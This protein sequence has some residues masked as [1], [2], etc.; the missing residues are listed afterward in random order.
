MLYKNGNY[1]VIISSDGSKERFTKEDKFIPEYPECLDIK[2]TDHCKMGCSF[3]YESSTKANRHPDTLLLPFIDTL[4]PYTEVAININD[5][6]QPTLV[7]FLKVLKKK[8]VYTNITINFHY[9]KQYLYYIKGLQDNKLIHGIGISFSPLSS[10]DNKEL[11]HIMRNILKN[12]VVHLIVGIADVEL[13][14]E[15]SEN[16]AKILFLGYK[17]TGFGK[18][19]LEKRKEKIGKKTEE[20]YEFLNRAKGIDYPGTIYSFDNLAIEQ[21]H[22]H[23][24]YRD[25]MKERYMGDEGEFTFYIDIPNR[26]YYKNSIDKSKGYDFKEDITEMFKD[27]RKDYEASI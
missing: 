20:L 7:D 18:E 8:K 6:K 16:G 19:Y 24:I 14:K 21:L 2:I 10:M 5:C 3:C 4:K 9:L 23:S 27:I 12:C 17:D 13:V 11:Y 25:V 15:L 26:K 1:F 22:L